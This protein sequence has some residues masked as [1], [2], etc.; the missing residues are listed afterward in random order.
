MKEEGIGHMSVMESGWEHIR[1]IA[2]AHDAM[3]I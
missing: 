1:G 3:Q 2:E